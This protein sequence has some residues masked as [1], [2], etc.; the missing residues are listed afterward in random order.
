MLPEVLVLRHRLGDLATDELGRRAG[1]NEQTVVAPP[2]PGPWASV[3]PPRPRGDHRGPDTGRSRSVVTAAPAS[4]PRRGSPGARSGPFP[5]L[6]GLRG[7]ADTSR[8]C[9]ARPKRRLSE[10]G[11]SHPFSSVVGPNVSEHDGHG[12]ARSPAAARQRRGQ[13]SP[14]N[15]RSTSWARRC[16]R[17]TFVVVDL[18]TTG[19]SAAAG[20]A[21]TEIGAVKV[22]GGEV[23][24]EFQTLVDPSDADPAVHQRADRHHRPDG[25]RRPAD[26][27]GAAGVPRVRRGAR[28]RRAQ[29]AVRHRLPQASATPLGHRW[30]RFQV[31]DTAQLARRVVTRD[32]APNCKLS[33]LAALFHSD[34]DAQPPGARP[35]RRRPSTCCTA[36][37]SGSAPSACT[38]SRSCR[39]SSSRVSAAQRRKRHLAERLAPPARAS[40]SSATRAASALY[41]GTSQDLRTRVRTYFTASETAHAGWPRWSASPS[42]VDADRLRAPRSRP[43]SASCG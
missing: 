3:L 43:R 15:R 29:R 11:L 24:G 9:E 42:G 23:L 18:E 6:D 26:R 40:T 17:S 13:E 27:R 38:R 16:A 5:H 7:T 19:G 34:D 10:L 30:P 36:C 31:L 8:F 21:I 28:P 14:S 1:A 35:T 20:S 33:T 37:S 39:P 25:G 2:A 41:V 4:R 22:R 12:A 32:E